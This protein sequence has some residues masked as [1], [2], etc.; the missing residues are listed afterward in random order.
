MR[1][2][3]KKLSVLIILC[4]LA[5]GIAANANIQTSE[6]E[7]VQTAS[8]YFQSNV[9]VDSSSSNPKTNPTTIG[10]LLGIGIVSFVSFSRRD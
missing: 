6:N 4:I 10:F 5:V 1:M 7:R 8:T 2:M 9:A 3:M